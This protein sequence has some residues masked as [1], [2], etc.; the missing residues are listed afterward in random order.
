MGKKAIERSERASDNNEMLR[1]QKGRRSRMASGKSEKFEKRNSLDT[2]RV[3]PGALG[4]DK[5]NWLNSRTRRDTEQKQKQHM[6][7]EKWNNYSQSQ[8]SALQKQHPG[9]A[10]GY[11]RFDRKERETDRRTDR[12]TERERE[13]KRAP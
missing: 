3:R 7:L 6:G 10:K 9:L 8:K 12:Q 5:E 13:K 2:H 11:A 4:D 1:S